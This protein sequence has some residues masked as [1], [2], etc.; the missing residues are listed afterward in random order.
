MADIQNGMA[1]L[2]TQEEAVHRDVRS[3]IEATK[4]NHAE[5]KKFLENFYS[6]LGMADGRLQGLQVSMWRFLY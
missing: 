1:T 2:S 5:N 6:T 4:R 3:L